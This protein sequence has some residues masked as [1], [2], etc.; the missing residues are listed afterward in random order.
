MPQ[1][2]KAHSLNKDPVQPTIN[3]KNKYRCRVLSIV[4]ST[5][6]GSSNGVLRYLHAHTG[7]YIIHTE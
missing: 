6:Y 3:N 5:E 2:E 4:S 7:M 1:L